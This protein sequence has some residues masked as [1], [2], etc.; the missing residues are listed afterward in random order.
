MISKFIGYLSHRK[1]PHYSNYFL[2][3]CDPLVTERHKKQQIACRPI[4]YIPS[5]T[6]TAVVKCP[7]IPNEF[8]GNILP[9][10]LVAVFHHVSTLSRCGWSQNELLLLSRLIHVYP[11][12]QRV[13]QLGADTIEQYDNILDNS[14]TNNDT[15]M[16]VTPDDIAKLG[17]RFRAM[18]VRLEPFDRSPNVN[19]S[20]QDLARYLRRVTPLTR[21]NW[22]V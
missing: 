15:I 5:D 20:F 14:F 13:R 18:W 2:L 9:D 22:T 12:R 3:E 7:L 11:T 8:Y 17:K 16:A 6:I 1:L 10:E 19:D 4:N 21:R